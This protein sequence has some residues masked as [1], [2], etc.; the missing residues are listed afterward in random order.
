MGLL[1][2]ITSLFSTPGKQQKIE[3]SKS[4]SAE[5]LPIIYGRRRVEPINVFKR[6]SR[7]NGATSSAIYDDYVYRGVSGGH[8]NSEK[9]RN[10]WLHRVDV[11][12]QG[13]INDV[14]GYWVDG[15]PA[16]NKRFNKRPFFRAATLYGRSGQVA[17][18]ALVSTN[19]DW[20]NAH[21]GNG[22][23]YS[24]T[25][26][27]QSNNHPQFNAEPAIK[28]EIEGLKVYD[29]RHDDTVPGWSGNQRFDDP[30]TWTYSN[31][32]ALV[33]LNYMMGSFGFNAPREELDLQSFIT[34][35]NLCD[36]A[37][38]IPA[39]PVNTNPAPIVFTNPYSG[40][41]ETIEYNED[42]WF[43]KP[44][45]LPGALTQKRYLADIV[46]DP[47]NDVVSNIKLILEEFGWSLSWS[48]GQHRLVIED[49][50]TAP[51]MTITADD[52]IGGWDVSRGN[53]SQRL[54][55][56]TVTF[57]NASKDY[58]SDTVSWPALRGETHNA[59]LAE[60]AGRDL[61]Q[62][63]T[64]ESI[65]DYHRAE[66][67]AEFKVRKSRVQE[68]ISGIEVTPK[69]MVLEPGDVIAIDLPEKGF[70]VSASSNLYHHKNLFFVERVDVSPT[71]TV[72]LDLRRYDHGIYEPESRTEEPVF[73]P[74]NSLSPWLDPEE[75]VDLSAQE[76]HD[77]KADGSVVSGLYVSWT[78]P[79][80]QVGIDHIEVKWREKNDVALTG[81]NYAETKVLLPDATA[82]KIEG[83]I[84]DGTYEILVTYVT[85]LNQRATDATLEVDLS[86]TVATKLA[87]IEA[88]ATDGATL[89]VNVYDNDGYVVEAGDLLTSDGQITFHHFW[90]FRGDPLGWTSNNQLSISEANDA[91][92]IST[93]GIDG[94]LFSPDFSVDGSRF[95]KVVVR[96]KRTQNTDQQNW[97]FPT[98]LYKTENDGFSQD[99]RKSASRRFTNAT[100]TTF[101]F[102]MANL[103]AG[104]DHWKNNT[105][106][107]LRFD[108]TFT[109]NDEFNIDWIGIGKVSLA[110]SVAAASNLV[111]DLGFTEFGAADTGNFE[112][113]SKKDLDTI[114][115]MPGDAISVGL[116]VIAD[117]GGNRR[118]RVRIRFVDDNDTVVADDVVS[119]YGGITG[120]Y[121]Q[122]AIEGYI[123]PVGTTAIRFFFD[124]E[125]GSVSGNVGARRLSM[126]KGPSLV[127]WYQPRADVE[128][129][130]TDGATPGINVK[131]EN[132]D[133]YAPEDLLTI[134][135]LVP[136]HTFDFLPSDTT[137]LGFTI[138]GVG[139]A[140]ASGAGLL[141]ENTTSD[142]RITSPSGLSIDGGLNSAVY[143]RMRR[144]VQGSA[145]AFEYPKL[146]YKAV[147]DG[148]FSEGRV[149]KLTRAF[150][151]DNW[152]VFAFDMHKASGDWATSTIDQIRFD[153]SQNGGG[154]DSFEIDWITIGRLRPIVG[155][156]DLSDSAGLGNTAQ[157][158][159]VSGRPTA[160]SDI[161]STESN[162]LAGIATN[163]TRNTG[164]L[165]DK[166]QVAEND[167]ANDAVTDAGS[168]VDA[169]G[170]AVL[171]S[172]T[173]SKVIASIPNVK[174]W[175]D[176][177]KLFASVTLLNNLSTR[178]IALQ[179][180]ASSAGTATG[181]IITPVTGSWRRFTVAAKAG[182]FS[183]TRTYELVLRWYGSAQNVSYAS[184]TI[185]WENAKK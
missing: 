64:R 160:L 9:D 181:E 132:G 123:I 106:T 153:P 72:R 8:D 75:I 184:P 125:T 23:A 31:N 21:I 63:Y 152:S 30:L 103:S 179:I 20:T 162:K 41:R 95:D 82:C 83:L 73:V 129:G 84:D 46:L 149:L 124:R 134:P 138:D 58:Q 143:V 5:G 51:A 182:S 62:N 126:N 141:L 78:A 86:E 135:A 4:A 169:S 22:V 79:Q 38:A 92:H 185:Q 144:T 97:E 116:Q 57:K 25:R 163:A 39:R 40:D 27:F 175:P 37:M 156:A 74:D 43:M 155:T 98:L 164:A 11:W 29:P 101:V 19:V 35:A 139:T 119:A 67:Y 112:V 33:L 14:K 146:Y 183:G 93:S 173:Q 165:A 157:Y 172:G 105:I 45:Q 130:A 71:L 2:F 170:T 178:N 145:D 148:S 77:T 94:Q 166:N 154:G 47:T 108:P 80:H 61:H 180:R 147:G 168:D 76:Y 136:V 151:G 69:A 65:T 24:W 142:P 174:G 48:N 150:V 118:G 88:G 32:R 60:D 159:Q 121:Q 176:G 111:D 110:A 117:I 85:R 49:A 7:N 133:P 44:F 3:L 34:A 54:N 171:S 26:F 70:E 52:L 122:V 36:S 59:L 100:A 17:M 42:L 140:S 99:R 90:D 13:E 68:R 28:A 104:G 66:A 102:D 107:G 10:R 109:S 18:S 53:R 158:D 16:S 127:G 161:N 177:A 50:I 137:F 81:D 6:V 113:F 1:S 167:I 55:R 56:A 131:D 128:E 12:G 115:L 114:G 89:G 91:I 96:M 120:T 87:D 15:D